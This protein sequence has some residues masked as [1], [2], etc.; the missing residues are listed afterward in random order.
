LPELA[1]ALAARQFTDLF[2]RTIQ[3][4]V[5][6]RTPVLH[7]LIAT[8]RFTHRI[9]AQHTQG[10]KPLPMWLSPRLRRLCSE[11]EKEDFVGTGHPG[12]SPTAIHNGLTWWTLL[13][14]MPHLKPGLRAQREYRYPYLDRDLIEFLFSVP[15]DQLVRPGRRRSLMRRALRGVVPSEILERRRKAYI[16]RGPTAALLAASHEI[17]KLLDQP[18]LSQYGYVDAERLRSSI[19]SVLSGHT[20]QDLSTVF[21][22]MALEIWLRHIAA[23][24]SSQPGSGMQPQVLFPSGEQTSSMQTESES[25]RFAWKFKRNEEK[26]A[27]HKA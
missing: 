8:A 2:K 26:H 18:L 22:A 25:V 27:L 15:R 23:G 12:F 13:E 21:R 7:R 19:T 11:R 5:A 6:D 4:C 1:D 3:W 16:T 14:T 17:A 9:Y 20:P 10:E 24:G